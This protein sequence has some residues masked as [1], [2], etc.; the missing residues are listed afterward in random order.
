MCCHHHR[1]GREHKFIRYR[2]VRWVPATH[3]S[4]RWWNLWS[5][6]AD[7]RKLSTRTRTPGAA[8]E[9]NSFQVSNAALETNSFQV[10]FSCVP[11]NAR[12]KQ[13]NSVKK[14]MKKKVKH[15][16][17]HEQGLQQ[18]CVTCSVKASVKSGRC[19][20]A[21]RCRSFHQPPLEARP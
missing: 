21:T 11:R 5:Q 1:N 20:A 8:L 9:T 7:T 19:M 13:R 4:C 18:R 15:N 12:H 16:K 3:R 14:K 17:R 2:N 10:C 6:S